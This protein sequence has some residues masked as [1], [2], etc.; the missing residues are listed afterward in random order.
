[1][2]NPAKIRATVLE[3]ISEDRYGLH[4]LLADVQAASPDVPESVRIAAATNV[5]LEMMQQGAIELFW[6]RWSTQQPDGII[7]AVEAQSL[8]RD[9]S[10]WR[11]AERYIAFGQ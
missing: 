8:L 11:P 4:E 1:M 6:E 5:L 9:P 7:S 2:V 3:M 10:L